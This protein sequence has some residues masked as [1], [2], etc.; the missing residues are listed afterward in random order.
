MRR[1]RLQRFAR[2]GGERRALLVEAVLWLLVARMAL[3]LV[4]FHR[5]AAWLGPLE[6]PG[7]RQPL[8]AGGASPQAETAAQVGW[9]VICA[10]RH[11]P[12]KAVCLPQAIAGKAMLRR[13]GVAS[14]LH[15]GAAIAAGPDAALQAHAWLDAAGV[16]VTGYPVA[17]DF[18]EIA[19]F[20]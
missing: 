14:V 15:L 1:S 9:A 19:S 17:A 13:R 20:A 3:L 10:A 8:P 16:K 18:T 4:S 2:M 12:F 6:P 5:I 11:V 7:N